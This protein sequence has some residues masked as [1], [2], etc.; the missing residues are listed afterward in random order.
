MLLS[1]A[2]LF[3]RFVPGTL[4]ETVLPLAFQRYFEDDAAD[5]AL[6]CPAA[7]SCAASLS[8]SGLSA[9]FKP[10]AFRCPH[11]THTR[12]LASVS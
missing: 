12:R 8:L 2:V 5:V 1:S 7:E 11:R 9:A 6:M 3:L 10:T 4:T